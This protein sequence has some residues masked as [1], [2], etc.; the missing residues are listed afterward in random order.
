MLHKVITS[1]DAA[2]IVTEHF[3][4]SFKEVVT[5]VTDPSAVFKLELYTD[6]GKG[7]EYL[8]ETVIK[9]RTQED[10]YEAYDKIV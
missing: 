1:T 10:Y 5:Q 3:G 8:N 6:N 2:G 4:L 9:G 7:W